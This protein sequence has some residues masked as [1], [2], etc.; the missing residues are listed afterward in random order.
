VNKLVEDKLVGDK[1][2]EDRFVLVDCKAYLVDMLYCLD[3]VDSKVV[4]AF[5]V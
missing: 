1:L 5:Q 4:L 2:V 3:K